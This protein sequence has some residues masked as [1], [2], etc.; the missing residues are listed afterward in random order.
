MNLDLG[1]GLGATATAGLVFSTFS[2]ARGAFS[3]CPFFKRIDTVVR[4]IGPGMA[5]SSFTG[6]ATTAVPMLEFAALAYQIYIIHPTTTAEGT[7]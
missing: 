2:T 4:S 3:V 7:G 1:L 5:F 6:V